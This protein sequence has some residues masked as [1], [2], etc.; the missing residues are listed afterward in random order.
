MYNEIKTNILFEKPIQTPSLDEVRHT[1][2]KRMFNMK[3]LKGLKPEKLLGD[4]RVPLYS[5][6]CL[7][8]IDPS[9]AVKLSV[10]FG[11]FISVLQSLGT[12]RHADIIMAAINAEVSLNVFIFKIFQNKLNKY[13]F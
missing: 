4:V 13:F 10:S 8:N 9:S 2:V 3:L 6:K 5:S 11:M 12:K 7:F 1:A